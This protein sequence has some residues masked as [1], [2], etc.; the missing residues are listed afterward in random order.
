M[1]I[2]E[3][4]RKREEERMQSW[5]MQSSLIRKM[6]EALAAYKEEASLYWAR[7]RQEGR[8]NGNFSVLE[9]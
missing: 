6:G 2:Y 9:E 4:C 1:D 5:D 8:W 3:Y 7:L